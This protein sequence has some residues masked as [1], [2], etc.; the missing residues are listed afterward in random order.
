[1]IDQWQLR[2]LTTPE[3]VITPNEV[4]RLCIPYGSLSPEERIEIQQHVEHTYDFLKAIPWTRDLAA[5]PT[6]P[7]A[8]TKSS[9]VPAIREGSKP[10]KSRWVP[11]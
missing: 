3:R 5:Y 1:M 7:T 9:T 10:Q 6:S 11:A 2:D 8:I 4:G